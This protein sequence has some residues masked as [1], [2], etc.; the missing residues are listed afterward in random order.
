MTTWLQLSHSH[1][2]VQI[3][4][5]AFWHSAYSSKF[6]KNY[7][8][9][10]AIHLEVVHLV[11]NHGPRSSYVKEHDHAKSWSSFTLALGIDGA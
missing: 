11:Y 8:A 1:K 7:S 4:V 2:N 5:V 6:A 10:L 3:I 9:T